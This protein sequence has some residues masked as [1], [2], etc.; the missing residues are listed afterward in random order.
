MDIR[1]WEKSEARGIPLD[2]GRVEER[3]NKRKNRATVQKVKTT[4]QSEREREREKHGLNTHEHSLIEKR[5]TS[6]SVNDINH[7][8]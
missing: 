4:Q 8:A 2:N 7:G 6:S 3:S 5:A 1:I